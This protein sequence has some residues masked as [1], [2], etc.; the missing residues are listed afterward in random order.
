MGICRICGKSTTSHRI[1]SYF[2]CHDCWENKK[3]E[4]ENIVTMVKKSIEEPLKNLKKDE[5]EGMKLIGIIQKFALNFDDEMKIALKEY[6][7]SVDDENR[8]IVF[9]NHFTFERKMKSK[10]KT[11]AE[12]FVDEYNMPGWVAENIRKL[13]KPVKGFF[14]VKEVFPENRFIVQD[15]FSKKEYVLC[16]EMKLEKGDIIGDEIYPWEDVYLTGGAISLYTKEHAG[17][18]LKM[19]EDFQKLIEKSMEKQKEVY[20]KFLE[21]FGKDDPT[22]DSVDSAKKA[23]DKFTL[24]MED[25]DKQIEKIDSKGDVAMVCHPSSGI[26]IIPDYGKLKRMLKGKEKGDKEYM[27]KAMVEMPYPAIKKLSEDRKNF[28]KAIKETFGEDISEEDT[29]SF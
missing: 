8:F 18:I 28:A 3:E 22:F 24:W 14:E 5:K 10:G 15:I 16:G 27:K 21:Y 23:L 20:A 19:A 13:Q 2:I 25:P 6:R 9:L 7:H 29:M 4:V 1:G 17:K 26:Y 11:P 12:L